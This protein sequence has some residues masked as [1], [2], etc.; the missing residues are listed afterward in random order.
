LGCFRFYKSEK[1]FPIAL[2]VLSNP[3]NPLNPKPNV[4]FKIM[5]QTT[6]VLTA[7]QQQFFKRTYLKFS[8][9]ELTLHNNTW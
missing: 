9:N 1:S 6:V 4:P 5:N 3:A 8:K 7:N 2:E